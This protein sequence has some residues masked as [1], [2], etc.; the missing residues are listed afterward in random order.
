MVF[1][2]RKLCLSKNN[3]NLRMNQTRW[4]NTASEFRHRF[5]PAV[6]YTTGLPW[7]SRKRR[8]S[9]RL[10]L[11]QRQCMWKM[12]EQCGRVC[13]GVRID[14]R[15]SFCWRTNREKRKISRYTE[16][17]TFRCRD[18][19]TKGRRR[20]GTS[21]KS[22]APAAFHNTAQPAGSV[23]V[24]RTTESP[25]SSRPINLFKYQVCAAPGQRRRHQRPPRCRSRL[26]RASTSCSRER[27][28][29]Q[30]LSSCLRTA[31]EKI[32]CQSAVGCR[33]RPVIMPI[34]PGMTSFFRRPM[35]Y[36]QA[37]PKPR[38]DPHNVAG[39][40]FE[41]DKNAEKFHEVVVKIVEETHRGAKPPKKYDQLMSESQAVE[42]SDASLPVSRMSAR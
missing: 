2:Q 25:V 3:C 27:A 15:R 42:K 12:G 16:S 10:S 35:T 13:I 40:I 11:A 28:C 24:T 41:C 20:A 9:Q 32:T 36:E 6:C 23:V 14:R 4:K 37:S 18:E 33:G 30:D 34:H 8:S 26:V 5:R 38:N 31:V 22:A 7:P 21:D 39:L 1:D 17:K 29:R 19:N